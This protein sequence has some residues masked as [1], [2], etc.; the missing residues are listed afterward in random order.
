MC[1]QAVG[2]VQ[3]ECEEAGIACVVISIIDE[4]SETVNLP[5]YFSVPYELGYPLGD[6]KDFENQKRIC[7]E[8]LQIIE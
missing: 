7:R 5:R 6:P 8:A 3:K 4:I 1:P 2:L